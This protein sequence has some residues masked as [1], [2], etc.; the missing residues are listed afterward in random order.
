MKFLESKQQGGDQ[1]IIR[2]LV[3]LEHPTLSKTNRQNNAKVYQRLLRHTRSLP[4]VLVDIS[5]LEKGIHHT[6]SVAT[7]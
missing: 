4:C 7:I 6:D 1:L 3:S 5:V 2:L